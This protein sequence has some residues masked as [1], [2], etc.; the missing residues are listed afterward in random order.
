MYVRKVTNTY[1]KFISVVQYFNGA[2]DRMFRW[3]YGSVLR[4]RKLTVKLRF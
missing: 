4:E 3:K 2:Y 1:R